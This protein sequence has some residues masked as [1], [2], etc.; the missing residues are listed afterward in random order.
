MNAAGEMLWKNNAAWSGLRSN[1]A[2]GKECWNNLVMKG[3]F[4]ARSAATMALASRLESILVMPETL[5]QAGELGMKCPDSPGA[6]PRLPD[7]MNDQRPRHPAPCAPYWPW[8][9][10][11]SKA[12]P[13]ILLFLL[14]YTFP[15]GLNFLRHEPCPRELGRLVRQ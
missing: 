8:K 15:H 10:T 2:T 4:G 12:S 13:L 9:K 3:Q 5:I 14:L 7:R 6:R 1:P 11:Q